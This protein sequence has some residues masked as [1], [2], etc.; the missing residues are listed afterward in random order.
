MRDKM[1][2]YL[3][4]HFTGDDSKSE[5]EQIY[6]SVSK[7]GEKWDILNGGRAILKNHLSEKGV[8]DPF[9]IRSSKDN[10]FYIIATDLSIY[11]R[12]KET[13]EKTAWVQCKNNLP[14]NPHSGSK[15][16]IVWKSDNLIDWNNYLGDIAPQDAGCFWAPKCIWDKNKNSYMVFGASCT[17]ED[18]YSLLKLYR[19]YTEDFKEFSNPEL[20]MDASAEKFCVFD[21]TIVEHNNMYYRIFKTDRIKI[22]CSES[23]DGKW[24]SVNTNI[25]SLAPLHEGPAIYKVND[26]NSWIL[27]LD[28][29]AS[30]GGYQS[31]ITDDLSQGQ[32]TRGKEVFP[33][34]IKYRHGSIIPITDKEYRLLI[35][36]YGV[37]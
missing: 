15:K 26:G 31:F 21:V 29:L 8:R 3:F 2:A 6:F 37:E 18:N 27:M 9:I 32:F 14:D 13:D 22:E 28:N 19:S 20:Y 4:V 12:K 35:K 25:H 17:S 5:H 10:K 34:G 16:M 11:N 30:R 23:L 7:D 36:T 33:K 24:T 1:S